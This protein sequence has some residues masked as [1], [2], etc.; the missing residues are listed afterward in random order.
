MGTSFCGL[1][2]SSAIGI[3]FI[4]ITE[5]INICPWGSKLMGKDGS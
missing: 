3:I 2:I 4:K 1:L 5:G